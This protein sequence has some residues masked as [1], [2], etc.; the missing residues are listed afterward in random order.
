MACCSPSPLPLEGGP[1][2]PLRERVVDALPWGP[3]V[4]VAEIDDAISD[5]ISPALLVP[6]E[7]GISLCRDGLV[8]AAATDVCGPVE[9]R[10]ARSESGRDLA[11]R[12]AVD[13]LLRSGADEATAYVIIVPRGGEPPLAYEA[14]VTAQAAARAIDCT[15]GDEDAESGSG[16]CH[17]WAEVDRG[18]RVCP[19]CKI[20]AEDDHVGVVHR[21]HY[22]TADRWFA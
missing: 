21:S 5:G 16:A 10:T 2:A 20:V 11:L 14:T 6:P 4:A 1:I 12:I 9:P 3:D 15:R 7:V 19:G 18:V 17:E 22:S 13:C 8:V